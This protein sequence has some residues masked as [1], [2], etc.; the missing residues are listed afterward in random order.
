MT[1]TRFVVLNHSK[2]SLP[3]MFYLKFDIKINITSILCNYLQDAEVGANLFIRIR[4]PLDLLD[5]LVNDLIC[6]LIPRPGQSGME[7]LG[8]LENSAGAEYEL[9]YRFIQAINFYAAALE[10]K[11]KLTISNVG[12]KPIWAFFRAG[13]S[14][15]NNFSI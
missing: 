9:T 11:I 4:F 8:H 7:T 12:N 14:R 15:G 1:V 5:R 2:I 3:R 13:Q 6:L 10:T